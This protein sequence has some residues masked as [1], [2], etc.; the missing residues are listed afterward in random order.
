MYDARFKDVN[1]RVCLARNLKLEVGEIFSIEERD[2]TFC[3]Q[4]KT[5]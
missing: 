3:E 4:Q 1:G 2:L 5:R